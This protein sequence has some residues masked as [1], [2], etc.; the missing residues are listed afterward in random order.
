[1][2]RI[3][4]SYDVHQLAENRKLILGGI[5]I[6]HKK[7][8]LG[9][10]DADVLLHAITESIIGAM[11]MGDIGTLF[12]DTDPKYKGI[13]SM[14]LLQEVVTI[15][16]ENNFKI[17]NIDASLYLEAPKMRPHIANICQNIASNINIE[18]N[19]INVKATRGER[20]GFIGR[21]EGIAAEAVVLLE[22]ND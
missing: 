19:Q 14:L 8:L 9:H 6:E 17:V 13:D 12:P 1:M 2:I 3:G 21:E 18:V 4:H 10:S 11:A 16:Q 22:K 5:E 20:M 7:G 15:M